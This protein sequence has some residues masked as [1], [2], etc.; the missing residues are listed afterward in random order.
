MVKLKYFFY[1]LI[2]FIFCY[3]NK[4]IPLTQSIPKNEKDLIEKFVYLHSVEDLIDVFSISKDYFKSESL[5]KFLE[6]LYQ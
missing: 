2:I 6:R 1:I 5:M 3:L 4:G